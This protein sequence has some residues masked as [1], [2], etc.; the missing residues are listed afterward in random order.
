MPYKLTLVVEDVKGKR[1]TIQHVKNS[2]VELD[3]AQKDE[4]PG[5]EVRFEKLISANIVRERKVG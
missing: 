2:I 1:R 5:L 4:L 3:D